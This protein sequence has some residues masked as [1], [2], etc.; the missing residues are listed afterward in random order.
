MIAYHLSTHIG[1]SRNCFTQSDLRDTL[2]E[3]EVDSC[4]I[5]DA[6][7]FELIILTRASCILGQSDKY[8][9]AAEL[10]WKIQELATAL[11]LRNDYIQQANEIRKK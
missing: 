6:R 7:T 3:F 11:V 2:N 10:L 5:V 1:S 4:T 8:R 9:E